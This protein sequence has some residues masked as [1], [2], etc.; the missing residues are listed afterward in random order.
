VAQQL[1]ALAEASQPVAVDGSIDLSGT[2][3]TI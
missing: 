1:K 3:I 2:P